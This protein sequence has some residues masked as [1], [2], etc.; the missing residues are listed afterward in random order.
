MLWRLDPN[1]ARSW[2][3]PAYLRIWAG[4]LDIALK[5]VLYEI[6]FF[7]AFLWALRPVRWAASIS[8]LAASMKRAETTASQS[9]KS[10]RVRNRIGTS[11]PAMRTG[12]FQRRTRDHDA[13]ARHY[14]RH[15]TR[16]PPIAERRH[17]ELFLS[18]LRLAM[19]EGTVVQ[20]ASRFRVPS[21]PPMS[22][23]LGNSRLATQADRFLGTGSVSGHR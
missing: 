14:P 13:A 3:P 9:R 4:Q 8:S 19:G 15:R 18:G 7:F 23:D 11:P 17:R 2:A 20:R 6:A 16:T 21:Q 12:S 10:F 22:R 5:F 1:S